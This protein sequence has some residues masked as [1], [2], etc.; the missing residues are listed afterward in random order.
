MTDYELFLA[1]V[2][3]VIA[4]HD[5]REDVLYQV[6]PD[7]KVSIYFLCN[8]LFWW[9]CADAEEITPENLPVLRQCVANLKAV[10]KVLGTVHVAELFCSM[11]RK[12]RPQ[13]VCYDGFEPEYWPLFDACGPEREVGMGNPYRPGQRRAL[14]EAAKASN[15]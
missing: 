13:G 2:F 11:V 12:E 6:T 7:R 10:D 9:G 15:Q 1:D 3:E 4:E 5:L 14:Q 8:D